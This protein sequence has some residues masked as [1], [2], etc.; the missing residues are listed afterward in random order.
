MKRE[1][2]AVTIFVFCYGCDHD[3]EQRK[4]DARNRERERL[5]REGPCF[6]EST[7][8]ATT[9]GSPSS[10]KCPNRKHRMHVQVATHPSNEEA[11]ALVFCECERTP[12][13]KDG[14]S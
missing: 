8:L 2:V 4:I 1:L 3:A 6:D 14:G 7:L 9:T 5:E 11:A 12:A 10:Y 13:P